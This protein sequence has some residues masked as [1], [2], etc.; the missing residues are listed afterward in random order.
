MISGKLP[1]GGNFLVRD[2]AVANR[3]LQG[4]VRSQEAFVKM[5]DSMSEAFAWLHTSNLSSAEQLDATNEL[6][7]YAKE[8]GFV[9]E[10][11]DAI[12]QNSIEDGDT[13]D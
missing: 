8:H 4:G 13:E 11:V 2:E 5:A 1:E 9:R 6:Y 12:L 3:L 10:D 7:A